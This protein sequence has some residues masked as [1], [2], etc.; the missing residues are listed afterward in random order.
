MPAEK[1]NPGGASVIMQRGVRGNSGP[2]MVPKENIG[3]P[4]HPSQLVN[5][6][7]ATDSKPL[8]IK[9]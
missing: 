9:T 2:G 5:T 4:S 8:N 7:N 3:V 1:N 6:L